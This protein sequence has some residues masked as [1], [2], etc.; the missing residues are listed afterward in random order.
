MYSNYFDKKQS[1]IKDF[2]KSLI[3]ASI[4]TVRE[5]SI[6]LELKISQNQIKQYPTNVIFYDFC[7]LFTLNK[8]VLKDKYPQLV[9]K[10]ELPLSIVVND[11]KLNPITTLN[12]KRYYISSIVKKTE[13]LGFNKIYIDD[14]GIYYHLKREDL[15]P[16]ASG[17]FKLTDELLNCIKLPY[18][19]IR[20]YLEELVIM[21][22]SAP[23]HGVF[24]TYSKLFMGKTSYAELN[25]DVLP[26][27]IKERIELSYIFENEEHFISKIVKY[28]KENG[29][30]GAN[31]SPNGITYYLTSKQLGPKAMELYKKFFLD[32]EDVQLLCQKQCHLKSYILDQMVYLT[33]AKH[34]SVIQIQRINYE[35]RKHYNKY[36]MNANLCYDWKYERENEPLVLKIY[37]DDDDLIDLKPP[38]VYKFPNL[39]NLNLLKKTD[40]KS[41]ET[42]FKNETP[43]SQLASLLSNQTVT[44]IISSTPIFK[45]YNKNECP[46]PFKHQPITTQINNPFN[47]VQ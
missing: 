36:G 41:N 37:V 21:P 13:E 3:D 17:Y 10:T 16:L 46:I 9:G 43:I 23:T 7:T 28:T 27:T 30:E 18:E 38:E 11:Y 40:I 12:N 39:S 5:A 14:K 8:V 44:T 31:V 2:T 22:S 42:V 29:F 20:D 24:Y 34:Y 25:S 33:Y 26:K 1:T 19:I 47:K 6:Y 35:L 15:G 32:K 45:L 4:V